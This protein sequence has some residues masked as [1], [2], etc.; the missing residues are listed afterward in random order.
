MYMCVCVCVCVY[1]WYVC[2]FMHIINNIKSQVWL[3]IYLFCT[4][5]TK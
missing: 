3:Y 1:V 2:M 4:L 5:Y